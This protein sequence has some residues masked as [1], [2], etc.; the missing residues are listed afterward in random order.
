SEAQGRYEEAQ[1]RYEG[2]RTRARA[3][4]GTTLTGELV[5]VNAKENSVRL[6]YWKEVK[7][8]GPPFTGMGYLAYEDFPV[9]KDARVLQD[10]VK[11]KLADL[12]KGS[13]VTLHLKGKRVV[14]VT[15]DGGTVPGPTRCVSVNEARNTVTV[16]AGRKD[17][18]RVYHLL[19]E[20]EVMTAGGKAAGLKDLKEGMLLLLTR[21]VEDANTVLRIEILSPEKGKEG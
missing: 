14:S 12:K 9:A 6:A 2:A 20:T 16:I 3:K 21:S 13:H 11:T 19:K 10:N 18:R 4:G 17:E 8:K 1:D 7:M 5:R 15:A